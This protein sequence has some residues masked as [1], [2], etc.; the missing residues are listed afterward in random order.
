MRKSGQFKRDGLSKVLT[1]AFMLAG[2]IVFL[3]TFYRAEVTFNGERWSVYAKYYLISLTSIVLY[4]LLLCLKDNIRLNVIMVSSSALL[5]IY[6][7][8]MMLSA[9]LSSDLTKV[10]SRTAFQVYSDLLD[11]GVDVVPSIRPTIFV[12]AN[13]VPTNDNQRLYPLAGVSNR[14]TVYCNESGERVIYKSDKYGFRNP[15][16]AWNLKEKVW[17]V[18]GDSFAHG[19]CVKAGKHAAARVQTL[20]ED[21]SVINLGMGGSGPL[22]ELAIFKEYAEVL[23]P[24]VIMWFYFEGNDLVQNLDYELTSPLLKNYLRPS[25]TQKLLSRQDE[26]DKTLM[27][28]IQSAVKRKTGILSKLEVIVQNSRTLRLL[29]IRR[30]LGVDNQGWNPHIEKLRVADEFTTILKQV[31]AKTQQWG[32]E[33]Y[34]VYIPELSRYLL[35]DPNNL[36]FRGRGRILELVASLNM[37]IIDIHQ[38]VFQNHTDPLS[39]FPRRTEPHYTEE[40]YNLVGSALVSGI[41]NNQ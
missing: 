13:G 30:F 27:S 6:L 34:F 28:H 12:L 1:W 11:E 20:K 22:I 4:G 17:V 19:A 3:Y 24:E 36:Q 26:I 38:D 32:G 2:I 25:Y 5:G 40:G 7:L 41:D 37:P 21:H 10:D 8:E 18:I 9:C 15:H 39:L 23:K 14:T 29:N 35:P 31:Q 16:Q 33:V